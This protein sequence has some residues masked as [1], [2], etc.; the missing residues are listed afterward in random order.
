MNFNV[1]IILKSNDTKIDFPIYNVASLK[2]ATAHW[3]DFVSG[4]NFVT[5]ENDVNACIINTD[6]ISCIHFS[7]ITN[8]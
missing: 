2:A 5:V 6:D 3:N 1:S 7:A 4:K 8:S